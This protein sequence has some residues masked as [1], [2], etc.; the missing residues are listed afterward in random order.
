MPL[1]S[2]EEA[3]PLDALSYIEAGKSREI[4]VFDVAIPFFEPAVLKKGVRR[5]VLKDRATAAFD[6]VPAVIGRWRF[7]VIA[8]GLSRVAA[9]N[10]LDH[11]QGAGTGLVST[12]KR[13]GRRLRPIP[14]PQDGAAD[15]STDSQTSSA[16]ERLWLWLLGD[17]FVRRPP[18]VEADRERPDEGSAHPSRGESHGRNS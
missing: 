4:N 15:T 5:I 18:P 2:P 14:G 16:W 3:G 7:V 1:V 6:F 17:D 12:E 13:Y 10:L 9:D 11:I 8:V